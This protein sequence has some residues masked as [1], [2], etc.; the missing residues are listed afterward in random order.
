MNPD[1]RALLS[2]QADD[3]EIDRL[4]AG[5]RAVD[6]RVEQLDRERAAAAETL[7]RARELLAAEER[8]QRELEEKVRGHRQLKEKYTQQLDLVRRPREATA[9]MAQLDL[10]RRVLDAEEGEL[11]ALTARVRDLRRAAE[12]HEMELADLDE[13]QAPDREAAAAERAAAAAA[14]A[15]AR[16]KR[17]EAAARVS[18]AA[19]ARYERIRARGRTAALYPLDGGSCSNCHTAIP[20]QRRSAILSGR[21]I[22]A[23][24]G[25]GVLLYASV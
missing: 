22:E 8:R 14:V 6:G 12:L 2:L 17:D 13:R 10:T 11:Q 1:L 5:V 24:E 18:K 25:C 9:A 23:C 20:T 16:A 4:E 15:T 19:L 3:L 21:S 7:Q